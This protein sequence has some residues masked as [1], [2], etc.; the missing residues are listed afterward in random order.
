MTSRCSDR[1]RARRVHAGHGFA[2]S[3]A[4]VLEPEA[5]DELMRQKA[6]AMAATGAAVVASA[7]LG[8]T[9]QI[10]AGLKALGS[11]ALVLHPIEI[12]DHAYSRAST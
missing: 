2:D 4:D 3:T 5:S 1:S 12:L 7:N 9:M 8:C 6:V 10:A 11:D